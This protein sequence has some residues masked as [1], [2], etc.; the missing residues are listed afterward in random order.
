[1][2]SP[3]L[4]RLGIGWCANSGQYAGEFGEGKGVAKEEGTRVDKHGKAFDD[5]K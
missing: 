1:L 4:V 3:F 5:V 2:F